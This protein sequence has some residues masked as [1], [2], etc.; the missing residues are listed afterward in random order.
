MNDEYY[1]WWN[2]PTILEG[3]D[4][5]LVYHKNKKIQTILKKPLTEYNALVR[6]YKWAT[7]QDRSV[8]FHSGMNGKCNFYA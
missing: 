7:L 1:G 4:H 3:H 6:M 5:D 2:V 8:K